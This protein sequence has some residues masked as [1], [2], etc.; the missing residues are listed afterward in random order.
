MPGPRGQLGLPFVHT[1]AYG[2]ADFLA[3]ASNEVARRWLA[4]DW[5]D[6]RLALWGPEGVGKTHL[7]TIEARRRGVAVVAG[8][9]LLPPA[10]PPEAS[11][12]IDDANA[13]PETALLHWLNAAREAGQLVLL[14]ARQA[15]ARW[16]VRLP[17]LASRLRAIH[18]VEILPPGDELLHALL[19]RLLAQRGLK[20]NEAVQD[21]LLLR[22]PRSAA[23]M[24]EAAARLDRAQLAAAG[25]VTRAFAATALG[26]LLADPDDVDAGRPDLPWPDQHD[27]SAKPAADASSAPRPVR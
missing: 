11:C 27:D 22:L 4:S 10:A 17:D 13:A 3:A 6:G 23:A 9:D 1:P 12:V 7:L 24:R 19:A 15:P 20:V 21:W 25:P 18:A 2:D 26:D 16:P 14:A 8:P 5:P